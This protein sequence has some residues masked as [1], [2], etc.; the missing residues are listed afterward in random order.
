MRILLRSCQKVWQI[1]KRDR[2]FESCSLWAPIF[3]GPC[4]QLALLNAL[5]ELEWLT[6]FDEG[7]ARHKQRADVGGGGCLWHAHPNATLFGVLLCLPTAPGLP[8]YKWRLRCVADFCAAL[9]QAA[10]CQYLVMWG[11]Q[12][13]SARISAAA[14]PLPRLTSYPRS[15]GLRC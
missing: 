12:L 1:W 7:S 8:L 13:A 14:L 2:Y 4:D 9:R 5:K 15:T 3:R 11:V 10:A 6:P